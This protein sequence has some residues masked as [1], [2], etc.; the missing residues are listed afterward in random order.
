[1]SR[2]N[3]DAT[4]MKDG[5]RKKTALLKRMKLGEGKEGENPLREKYSQI[6][7]PKK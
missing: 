2:G 1:V 3:E 5:L 7:G 4:H 6:P